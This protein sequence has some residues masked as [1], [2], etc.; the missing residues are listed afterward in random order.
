MCDED[1]RALTV[2]EVATLTPEQ[3][4]QRLKALA[5]LRQQAR[6]RRELRIDYYP[7]RQAAKVIRMVLEESGAG[8]SY[9]NILD[10]IIEHWVIA[11]GIN[12][13]E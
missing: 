6:R 1:W 11:S 9:T 4:R 7:S 5:R 13:R 12:N 2:A 8:A 3:E 10:M